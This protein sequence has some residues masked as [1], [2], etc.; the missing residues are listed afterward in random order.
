MQVVTH[1]TKTTPRTEVTIPSFHPHDTTLIAPT[2]ISTPNLPTTRSDVHRM[3]RRFYETAHSSKTAQG[4]TSVE[5]PL[6]SS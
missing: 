2:Q 5:A 3:D 4:T 1:N 6:G